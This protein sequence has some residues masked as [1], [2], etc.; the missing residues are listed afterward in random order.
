MGAVVVFCESRREGR[1]LGVAAGGDRRRASWP[2]SR[3]PLV[4][5]VIGTGVGAAAARRRQATRRACWR[6]TTPR[7]AAPL[8]E[9]WAPLL[10]DAR[11]ARRA[12]RRC[13]APRLDR[14]GRAAARGGAA[15]RRDGV[16]HHRGRWAR[17]RFR[18]PAYA[19]NAIDEVEVAGRV[20]VASV[21]QTEFPPAAPG[22]R[23]GAGRDRAVGARRR[24]GRR[25]GRRC[26]RPR[27]R[28]PISPRPRSSSPAAA[29]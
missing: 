7:S 20:V 27:A 26:T 3:R 1:A 24:A 12:P 9:T 19:G 17:T 25:A 22:R 4:G 28:A 23:G 11:Q 15:R 8:A 21:R 5:V 14:Q 13:S 10:A 6:T 29:A 2:S 18:R 16:R